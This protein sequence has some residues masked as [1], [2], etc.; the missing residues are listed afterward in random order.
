MKKWCH[1]TS[2]RTYSVWCNMR[3]RCTNPKH[4]AA[5]YY[6]DRGITVCPEW[7]SSYDQFV[8][9]MGYAPN[10]LTLDRINTNG[11]YEP[12]NCRWVTQKVQMNNTRRN[13]VIEYKGERRTLSNWA[14]HLGIPISTLF[15]RLDRGMSVE[16]ALNKKVTCGATTHGNNTM[17]AYGCRCDQCKEAHRAY[18]KAWYV[19]KKTVQTLEYDL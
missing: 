12:G 9:D 17:Y 11:N 10:G 16:R 18:Q 7:V 6:G 5:K 4:P 8:D 19:R 2:H 3:Y 1:D 13:H 15:N 14:K